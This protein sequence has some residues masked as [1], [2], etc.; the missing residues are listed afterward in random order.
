MMSCLIRSAWPKPIKDAYKN[1]KCAGGGG[2]GGGEA[3][4]GGGEA[5]WG[6]GGGGGAPYSEI[7]QCISLQFGLILSEFGSFFKM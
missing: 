2:G 6:E 3:K 4:G 5:D 7:H 1:M